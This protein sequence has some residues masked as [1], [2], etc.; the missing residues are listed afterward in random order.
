MVD[1]PDAER[2]VSHIVRPCWRRREERIVGVRGL[3]WK[4][5]LLYMMCQYLEF[6]RSKGPSW[7]LNEFDACGTWKPLRSPNCGGA[8]IGRI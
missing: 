6:E 2:P 4:V 5:M 8:R 3:G 7:S 1:L